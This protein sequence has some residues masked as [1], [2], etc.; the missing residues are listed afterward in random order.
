MSRRARWTVATLVVLAAVTTATYAWVG[1]PL[2]PFD[3]CRFSR[4]AWNRATAAY[5]LDSRARMSRDI[6]R[7]FV[8]PG[9]SEKEVVALLGKPDRVSD[10]RGPGGTPLPGIHIYEYSLGSWTSQRMDDAFLYVHFDTGERVVETE[11]YGY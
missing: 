9:L 2:D 6:M 4:D 1:N 7:R 5:D 3:D 11:I 8:R 10:R